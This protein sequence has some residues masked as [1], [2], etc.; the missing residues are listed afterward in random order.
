[1]YIVN[2]TFARRVDQNVLAT[3]THTRKNGEVINV[4]VNLIVKIIS[5]CRHVLNHHVVHIKY[6]Q[7]EFINCTSAKVEES[8]SPNNMTKRRD[9]RNERMWRASHGGPADA[10]SS[11]QSQEAGGSSA[12]SPRMDGGPGDKGG[13]AG[14]GDRLQKAWRRV[15]LMTG[16]ASALAFESN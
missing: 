6:I 9:N 16:R 11:G 5:Q 10:G 15:C 12:E 2:L 8:E 7:F 14:R 1:M 13:T 4:Y 3:H